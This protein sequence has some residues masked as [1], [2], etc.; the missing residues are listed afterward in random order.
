ML[1]SVPP[2]TSALQLPFP[3]VFFLHTSSFFQSVVPIVSNQ[4]RGRTSGID[5]DEK[6][7]QEHSVGKFHFFLPRLLSS[8]DEIRSTD[9]PPPLPGRSGTRKGHVFLVLKYRGRR[10]LPVFIRISN[11]IYS[12]MVGTKHIFKAFY[13]PCKRQKRCTNIVCVLY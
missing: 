5:R 10:G 3:S 2:L 4:T 13:F 9:C 11:V 6:E 8:A 12:E 7:M 1:L